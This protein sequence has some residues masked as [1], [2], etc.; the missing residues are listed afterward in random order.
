[1]LGGGV[2]SGA[3]RY[4]VTG[5]AKGAFL[6]GVSLKRGVFTWFLG[7]ENVVSCW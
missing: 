3:V 1:M 6:Q 4:F 2:D 7:G 5:V